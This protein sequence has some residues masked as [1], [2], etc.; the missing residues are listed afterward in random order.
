VL[1]VWLW[2]VLAAALGT[3]DGRL[4]AA[5]SAGVFA[6]L[7]VFAVG[8]VFPLPYELPES[9]PAPSADIV[10]EGPPMQVPW[11]TVYLNR[12]WV[13]SVNPESVLTTAFLSVLVGLN[14]AAITYAQRH[15]S[16]RLTR[17]TKLSMIG[18]LPAFFAFFSCCGSGFVFAALTASGAALSLIGVLQDFSRLFVA[19]SLT[20]LA[21]NLYL[22]C[23]QVRGVASQR[24]AI[25]S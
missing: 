2:R 5:A 9:F 21:A 1:D 4:A 12:R 7:Y 11:L 14:A 3:G 22:I 23:R 19:A 24:P 10:W 18:V 15:A 25:F 20:V 17:R 6:A 13:V 8:M 16:C